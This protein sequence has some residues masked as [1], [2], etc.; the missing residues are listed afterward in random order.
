MQ[1]DFDPLKDVDMMYTEIAG[2]NMVEAIVETV[3][4][5]TV[6]AEVETKVDVAE[7]Q[8][9]DITK[10]PQ[11]VKETITKPPFDEKLKA[12][13]PTIEEKLIDFLNRCKLKN[14]VMLCPRCSVVFDKE[15]TKILESVIPKSKKR[16][17]WSGDHIPKFS[18]TKSYIPFINNSSTTNFV[19]KNGQGK[20]FVPHANAP[21]QRWV[22]STHKNVQHG[23]NNIVKGGTSTIVNK[24]GANFDS[25]G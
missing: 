15:V 6:K 11:T 14:E 19:S 1:V 16:G 13:Y 25:K 12:A 22:R 5:L 7:C 23:R 3:E 8:M 4:K 2:C 9:V 24:N 18:F 10:E 21:A 17:K 20:V